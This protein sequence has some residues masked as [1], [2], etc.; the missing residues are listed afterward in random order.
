MA[1][2][3]AIDWL[4]FSAA[5]SVAQ[6]SFTYTPVLTDAHNCIFSQ[7]WEIRRGNETIATAQAA[8]LSNVVRSDLVVVKIEN[9]ILYTSELWQVVNSIILDFGLTP[10]GITR[11][12]ICADFQTLACGRLPATLIADI[13]TGD[14]WKKGARCEV[15][16]GADMRRIDRLYNT[17]HDGMVAYFNQ[18]CNRAGGQLTGYRAGS[19]SSAVCEY[20]YNKTIEL[21]QQTDKPYIRQLWRAVGFRA[22]MDVWRLEF[23]LKGKAF[24]DLTLEKLQAVDLVAFYNGL[25]RDYFTLQIRHDRDICN[26]QILEAQT[27]TPPLTPKEKKASGDKSAKLFISRV[28][29]ELKRQSDSEEENA[30][31]IFDA[32][33]AAIIEYTLQTQLERYF[34][35]KMC[36]EALQDFVPDEILE[37]VQSLGRW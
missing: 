32:L 17:K 25:L 16:H 5:G 2:Y 29:R 34:Y 14:V 37:K 10:I 11:L 35:R 18:F 21:Q 26:L 33:L 1:Y 15:F 19:R 13:F 8:P 30:A 27:I 9:H 12:D 24:K 22:D 28:V 3:V 31:A 36:F 6:G 4:Q 23:S 20:L 7:V